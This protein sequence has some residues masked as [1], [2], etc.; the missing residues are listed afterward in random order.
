[1]KQ[2][3]IAIIG[4]GPAGLAAAIEL[5]AGGADLVVI[6][7]YPQPGGHYF[8]QPPQEFSKAGVA[9]DSRQVEY[10]SLMASLERL[11]VTVLSES[12]VWSIF[13][14]EESA[15]GYTLHLNG[16]HPVRSIQARYLLLA[17]GAYDRPMAFPGW[18]LPGVITP[19][20]AQMLMKGHGILPGERILGGG[21]GP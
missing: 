5:A 20:G 8:R 15:T 4:G 18:R 11:N 17:S 9:A 3:E 12:A 1:M 14:A 19:G 21:S 2:V 16:P 13:P 7:A 6:D 10:A